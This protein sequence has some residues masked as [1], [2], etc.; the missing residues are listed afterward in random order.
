MIFYIPIQLAPQ[1]VLS[2]FIKEP[3]IVN[4]GVPNFRILFST[5]ILLGFMLM[6]ITMMQAMGKASKAS[7]LVMLRQIVLF[8]PLVIFLPKIGG[9]GVAGVFVGPPLTDLVV[10]VLT[11]IMLVSEF[12]NMTQLTVQ[13]K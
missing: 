10:V 13:G 8:I 1:T 12:R 7:I 6:V 11:A 5:Y 9:L 2:W 3:G 4:Q